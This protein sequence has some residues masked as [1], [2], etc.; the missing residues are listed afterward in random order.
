[1]TS[2][3]YM[4]V[5]LCYCFCYSWL[6]FVRCVDSSV[7]YADRFMTLHYLHRVLLCF[8]CYHFLCFFV[9]S[10]CNFSHHLIC[11]SISPCCISLIQPY[12]VL[13]MGSCVWTFDFGFL[14]SMLLF[15][16]CMPLCINCVLHP[17]VDLLVQFSH[18]NSLPFWLSIMSSFTGSMLF[19]NV[20]YI[21]TN[22]L[23]LLL[24][25]DVFFFLRS[26]QRYSSAWIWVCIMCHY[27]F[28]M[29]YPILVT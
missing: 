23:N 18:V 9:Q 11:H 7:V 27:I 8:S 2:L 5:Y 17:C 16:G 15:M 13:T 21:L 29:M 4:I 26:S 10:Y 6:W 25:S 12:L 28:V 14:L 1:M 24:T 20:I 19:Y 3:S 22:S